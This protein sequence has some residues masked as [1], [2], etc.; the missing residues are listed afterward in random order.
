MT[1]PIPT[2]TTQKVWHVNG[3]RFLREWAAYYAI[4]KDLLAK[5]YPRW[6]DDDNLED[7]LAE[8]G[9]LGNARASDEGIRDWRDRRDR[10]HRLFWTT[11]RYY[12]DAPTDAGFDQA[13]WKRYVTRVARRFMAA[14][15]RK[16]AP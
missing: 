9:T 13:K 16:S 6:L 10:R 2:V 5:K 1:R 12:D 15:R 4:A 3:R 7:E 14:D 11:Y 8:G